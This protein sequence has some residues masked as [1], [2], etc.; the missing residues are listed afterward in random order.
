MKQIVKKTL[1]VVLTTA[2]LTGCGSVNT[3][4]NK[5]ESTPDKTT[6]TVM[7]DHDFRVDDIGSYLIEKYPDVDFD[8]VLGRTGVSYLQKAAENDDLPDIII[9]SGTWGRAGTVLNPYLYDLSST[10]IASSFYS[11]YLDNYTTADGQ[12]YWLP[13][14]AAIEGVMANRTLFE[15]NGID[16]PTDYASFV[17]ACEKFTALGIR[18][19]ASDYKYDYTCA[20][21]LQAWSI[22]LL[23][24]TEGKDW[25]LAFED[26]ETDTLDEAIGLE[27]FEKL[28]SLFALTGVT[29]E[30]ATRGYGATASD[31]AAGNIAMI[32]QST[33]N[34]GY[35]D[36]GLTD[37][38]ILPYFGETADDSWYFTTPSY[39]VALN[40]ALEESDKETV[41]LDIVRNLFSQECMSIFAD[42]VQAFT[43]Y[44]KGIT[45]EVKDEFSNIVPFVESNHMY[46]YLSQDHFQSA[47]MIAVQKMIAENASA[48]EAW[49]AFN[50]AV[51]QPA[52]QQPA[53]TTF[54]VGYDRAWTESGNEALSAIVNTL[55]QITECDIMLAP[56][57]I[58]TGSVYA[59][60]YTAEQ[61]DNL[62]YGGG[63]N[64]YTKEMTGA[65]IKS[66]VEAAVAGWGSSYD[67][68]CASTLPVVSGCE[69]VVTQTADGSYQLNELL[70]DG[71]PINEA[72]VFH[73]VY[74]DN[75]PA[76]LRTVYD[77][78]SAD[79]DGNDIAMSQD[80]EGLDADSFEGFVYPVDHV[81][82]YWRGYFTDGGKL[83]SPSQYVQ[84][85]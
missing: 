54:E 74:T 53:V 77:W 64:F 50:E 82:E 14:C 79:H 66:L 2:T 47:S 62:L 27:L 20:Y 10:D 4:T 83:A 58:A 21:L 24:S 48:Q 61:I 84:L 70:V 6:V 76:L 19:Y 49:T 1:A 17:E 3:A 65:E 55:A 13:G 40:G 16:L 31:F 36:M 72:S 44:N 25:R 12:V 85:Q 67:P 52:E 75:T 38:V 56:F 68:I 11:V 34:S 73:F 5:Q 9:S 37:L 32:R 63:V 42:E 69:M 60:D 59:G 29:E 15:E 8:I 18:P 43:C 35:Y 22:P 7:V 51:V 33:N 71:N 39:A 46:T 80:A 45:F 81:A 23:Q 30:D 26:G 41:C 78:D 28:E 57:S